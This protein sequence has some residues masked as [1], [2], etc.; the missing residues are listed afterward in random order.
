MSLENLDYNS[1]EGGPIKEE[2]F[3][4][5]ERLEMEDQDLQKLKEIV[6]DISSQQLQEIQPCHL[7]L[8]LVV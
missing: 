2:Y 7:I 6:K 3:K 1:K 5:K 4:L 8:R